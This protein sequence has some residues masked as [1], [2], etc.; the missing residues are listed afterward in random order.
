M[1]R[2]GQR[3]K[4][5]YQRNNHGPGGFVRHT[6]VPIDKMMDKRAHEANAFSY[7]CFGA[8]A[9]R[10]TRADMKTDTWGFSMVGNDGEGRTHKQATG[11]YTSDVVIPPV[12]ADG[13]Y[14]FGWVWFGGTGGA[15][16]NHPYRTEPFWKGYFSDYWS[17]SFVEVRGGK[18]LEASY[19]P[20]FKND[21][22]QFSGEG[23]M[24]ANDAPG[25]CTHEPCVVYGKYQ[26]PRPFKAE[27]GPAA[28][29]PANFESEAVMERSGGGETEF[30]LPRAPS[31]PPSPW[32]RI[33]RHPLYKQKKAACKC[34]GEGHRCGRVTARK[35][36]YCKKW[37]KAEDQS[38]R[39]V[40]SCCRICRKGLPD[41]AR[42]C[43]N[44]KVKTECSL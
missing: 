17:C 21:M 4:V 28:L 8:T 6:L 42:Y 10:A 13:F 20:V 11:F 29:T 14:V 35:S 25:V 9:V 43:I 34:I 33:M 24:S 5:K 38:Q 44:H 41:M 26:K 3:I 30:R 12:V 1:L 18:A 32:E 39:C 7:S 36:G 15:V 40:R 2:R 37:T 27:G 16:S 23:C 31:P 22:R 19:T